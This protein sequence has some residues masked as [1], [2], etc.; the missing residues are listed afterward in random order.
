MTSIRDK[1]C[2]RCG[3]YTPT[4]IHLTIIGE[5]NKCLRCQYERIIYDGETK[6]DDPETLQDG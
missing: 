2:V 6:K 5:V 1:W 3:I 4:M